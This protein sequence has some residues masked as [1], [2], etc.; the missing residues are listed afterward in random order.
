MGWRCG[1]GSEGLITVEEWEE[2]GKFLIWEVGN[3]ILGMKRGRGWGRVGSR[4]DE[5]M[6]REEK[7]RGVGCGVSLT[8]ECND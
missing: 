4:M 8:F 7:E 6:G 5:W 1:V 3:F 2:G